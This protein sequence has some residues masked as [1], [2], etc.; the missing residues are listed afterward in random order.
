MEIRTLRKQFGC[1]QG[2]F[3]KMLG[4]SKN[5]LVQLERYTRRMTPYFENKLREFCEKYGI[6]YEP[7]DE[8][9]V[10]NHIK[11]MYWRN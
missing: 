3:S 9:N 1:T 8:A 11:Q 4:I 2:E 7:T 5:S 6:E 10:A